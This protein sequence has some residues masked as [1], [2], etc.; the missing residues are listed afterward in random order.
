MTLVYF[1]LM[2]TPLVFLHELGHYLAA[3]WFG[4]HVVSFAVGVGPAVVRWKP[5]PTE[6]A[7]RGLPLGGYVLLRGMVDD[8]DDA[9]STR[10]YGDYSLLDVA[11]WK[12]MIISLAGPVF[13]VATALPIFFSVG[14][15]EDS[16]LEAVVGFV[17]PGS[18]A[19]QAGMVPG[20]RVLRV[21]GEPVQYFDDLRAIIRRSPAAELELT[22]LRAGEEVTLTAVPDAVERLDSMTRL[23]TSTHGELGFGVHQQRARLQVPESL[24]NA[25][26]RTFD[27][28]L[29]FNGTD[30][31]TW[32]EFE[33][34]L[35]TRWT[36]PLRLTV[37]RPV[38]VPLRTGAGYVTRTL[39]LEWEITPEELRQLALRPSHTTIWYV[40]PGSPAAQAG[41]QV[42]D[43]LLQVD[44]RSVFDV[45]SAA[46]YLMSHE[47]GPVQVQVE[48][49]GLTLEHTLEVEAL[50]VTEGGGTFPRVFVGMHGLPFGYT[51]PDEVRI[52]WAR[53]IR[54]AATGAVVDTLNAAGMI[55]E[56]VGRIFAGQSDSSNIG[57]PLMIADIAGRAAA[58]GW[59]VFLEFVGLISINL[60]VMNMIPLP[61]L[62]GGNILVALWET[63]TRRPLS[64]R[65]RMIIGYAGL[66]SLVLIL[67]FVFKNDVQRYW[68]HVADWVNG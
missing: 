66:V 6:Y 1:L 40:E 29:S 5:G 41:L 36:R 22:I 38:G 59:L 32:L 56:I 12:R 35:Q 3:R 19:Q 7:L 67:L 4:V 46:D 30:V 61:G 28:V 52:P 16:R 49:D 68:V 60:G 25:P 42:G 34:Q 21:D 2:I 63:L 13:S 18:P 62:D 48:R 27:Q 8:G 11:P 33:A 17:A 20:D 53:R 58:A 54:D 65:A 45:A 14:L 51:F 15:T 10:V 50:Q 9:D 43:R 37:E 26:V 55:V 57:G 31:Q 24:L 44:E 39:E 64:A 47:N 23:R